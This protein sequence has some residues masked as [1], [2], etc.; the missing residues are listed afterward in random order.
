MEAM[1]PVIVPFIQSIELINFQ[2]IHTISDWLITLWN[3]SMYTCIYIY[4]YICL[5]LHTHIY[6]YIHMYNIYIY[7]PM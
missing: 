4:I 5:F 1:V 6:I 7:V 3:L 2:A